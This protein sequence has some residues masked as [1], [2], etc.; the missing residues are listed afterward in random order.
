[1]RLVTT[2]SRPGRSIEMREDEMHA[3]D[4]ARRLRKLAARVT[5]VFG[6]MAAM[7]AICAIPAGAAELE[8]TNWEAGALEASEAPSVAAG[9]HPFELRSAFS[10][11]EQEVEV[12][13][14]GGVKNKL[15]VPA[16][17]AKD[18]QVQLPPGAVAAAAR[19]PQ[20]S[21][22]EME[23]SPPATA[24]PPY[25]QVGY[26]VVTLN[27]LGKI[28][29]KEPVYNLEPPPGVPAQFGFMILASLT[30]V[31]FHVR[32]GSD[33]GVT[34]SIHNIN[35]TAP[36]YSSVLHIWGVPA[37]PAHDPV[38]EEL[39]TTLPGN[40][41]LMPFLT[42]PTACVGQLST[43][44]SVNSYQNP[45]RVV[46]R[47]A[48]SPAMEGCAAVPFR[49]SLRATPEASQAGT[50]TGMSVDLELPQAESTAGTATSA[51]KRAVVALPAG[52]SLSPG[53]ADGL[54]ACTDSQAG[55]G[56]ETAPAC[57]D[58]SKLGSVQVNTPLLAEPMEGGIYL[59]SQLSDDPAS[60]RMYRLFLVA[61]GS[62]VTIKLPGSVTADPN[63]GRLTATFDD[64]PQLPF[65]DLGIDFKG[66][67][68][69]PLTLPTECG[70]YTTTAQL[71]SWSEPG[72][73]V[74]SRSSFT[75][76]A[77]CGAA[78]RFTPTLEAGTENPV[79]GSSSPF[80]LKL[81]REDAQ[82]NV[83][84]ITVSLPEGEL[85]KLAGVP[86]CGEGLVGSGNCPAASQVGTLSVATGSGPDP[87]YLPEPGKAPTAVYLAGLYK[88]DPYSLLFKVPVQAGP[89]DFG[90]VLVRSALNID[91]V[92]TQVTAKSDPL[93]QIV[94]GVPVA[95]RTVYLDVDRPGF[96]Q[97][98]TSCDKAVVTSEIVSA[99]GAKANP[100]S[101][102]QVTN[103]G[104]LG[105]EPKLAIKFSGAP[106]RRG[107]HPKLTATL[108]TKSGDA[109][110]R[111]VQVTLP[112]TEYLENAHI[113]TVCTRVQ[114]AAK[115]CPAKSVYGFAKAWTP[116]LDKPLEGPVYLRSSSHK[117]PDL[118]ASLDGQI[119]IDL[120][121]RI[122]SV[123]SR[124]RNTFETVPDAPVSKFVLTMQGGGKG[125]LVNNTNICKARP[126]ANVEFDG[127]N[128][129][130]ADTEPLVSVGGCGKGRKP[131]KGK[132]R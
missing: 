44:L 13:E 105:L 76:D 74:E 84:S 26:A 47:E 126:R 9:A 8:I 109:N 22:E 1:M 132:G 96:T 17:N 83:Q 110:L 14:F 2:H 75:V 98:P 36:I 68:R 69:A 59:G 112:K 94:R 93:P 73:A 129:K 87:L 35:T 5:V 40:R 60:G 77:N 121:G 67:P 89:F 91:P 131:A 104:D 65:S 33:Y 39:G 34:A 7:L 66:G 12:E 80:I 71:S 99:R 58:D 103:C 111:R 90:T 122:S 118:V 37:A 10:F 23:E 72:T 127:Q 50:P 28:P 108:T 41:T 125:L 86:V 128:G 20:C 45:A 85:A 63:T 62:G 24:C 46:S 19:F 25:T 114:Y 64:N 82:Q 92:S 32:S 117:L 11:N 70:T 18:V 81:S 16:A 51:L 123:K 119:H 78:S 43:A 38:R 97:N 102:F 88:G 106:T 95:Y 124:I 3:G 27:L 130:V 42:N 4:P 30:H 116:L 120:D 48:A 54:A 101:P 31:N 57:P 56:T 29:F 61:S 55:I 107:G 21:Q 15:L 113:R 6:L 115:Q 53:A 49:P 79:A 52:V 100:N